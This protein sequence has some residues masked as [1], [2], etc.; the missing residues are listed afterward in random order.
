MSYSTVDQCTKQKPC[1]KYTLGGFGNYAEMRAEYLPEK[2]IQYIYGPT[3]CKIDRYHH[4][5]NNHRGGQCYNHASG[6]AGQISLE[7]N[8]AIEKNSCK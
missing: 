3:C 1:G 4:R 7:Q 2:K 5:R 8:N 6:M